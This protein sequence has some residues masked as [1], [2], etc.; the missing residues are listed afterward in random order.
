M[1]KIKNGESDQYGK[2]SCLNG[3][4]GERVKYRCDI[5]I[6]QMIQGTD[7]VSRLQI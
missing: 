4:G 2:V 5:K 6:V 7:I 1:T 3:I